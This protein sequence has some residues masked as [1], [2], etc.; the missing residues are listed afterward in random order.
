VIHRL[1]DVIVTDRGGTESEGEYFDMDVEG[2]DSK[3]VN[4]EP[5]AVGKKPGELYSD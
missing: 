2:S 3:D 4:I 5:K 1:S